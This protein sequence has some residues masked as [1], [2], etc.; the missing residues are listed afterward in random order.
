[1]VQNKNRSAKVAATGK[2][3]AGTETAGGSPAE[4]QMRKRG[5][6]RAYDPETALARAMAQFWDAGYAA[7]SLDDL[8]AATGM[9]RPSLYGAFGD[10]R[11]LYLKTLAIYRQIGSATMAQALAG[12]DPLAA[13]LARVYGSAIDLYLS[14]PIAA[15]GCYLI[16]TAATES[17]RDADIRESFSAGLHEFD[18]QITAR[19]RA[20]QKKGEISK[21]TDAA[22]LGKLAIGVLSSL[23]IRARAG[24]PRQALQEIADAGVKMICAK[25]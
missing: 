1:M 16:G 11:A 6:P 21:K 5:R 23:A 3:K 19:I 14:G 9:N 18:A 7:T 25:A 17:V 12:D 10:K 15:R 4:D 2:G 13:A 20:A 24:E 22:V 8:S